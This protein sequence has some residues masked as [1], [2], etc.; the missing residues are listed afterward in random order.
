MYPCLNSQR[1]QTSV[2]SI[3]RLAGV[4]FFFTL[5]TQSPWVMADEND[6][7]MGD[8]L[9]ESFGGVVRGGAWEESELSI[10]AQ[11]EK[12][13]LL[14][15]K[16]YETPQYQYYLD[17]LALNVSA[18]D[19]VVRYTVVIETPSGIR[20]VFYEGIRCDTQEYKTYASAL[21]GGALSPISEPQW[22]AVTQQGMGVYRYDLFKYYFCNSSIIRGSKKDILQMIEY[23]P[24]NFIDEELE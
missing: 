9:G 22:S 18:G 8:G 3:R 4:L 7:V 6:D 16:V 20:N 13:H 23:P 5:I 19:N 12:D 10:P 11:P 1:P 2:M 15:F 21:W 14:P 24:D 17:S